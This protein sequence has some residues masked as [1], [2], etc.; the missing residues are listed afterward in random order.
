MTKEE[1]FEAIE[2]AKIEG[3]NVCPENIGI[4]NSAGRIVGPCGQQNCW[5]KI[6]ENS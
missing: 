3:C 1:Y 5:I 4:E 6:Y 2:R